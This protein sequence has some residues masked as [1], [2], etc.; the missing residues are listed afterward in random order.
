MKNKLII[1]IF[2]IVNGTLYGQVH[3]GCCWTP[4]SIISGSLRDSVK[5]SI[6]RFEKQIRKFES[7]DSI[8]MPGEGQ[9]LFVGSSSIRGWLS[10]STDM[11]PLPVIRRGFGGSTLPE[12]IHFA[13]RIIYKYKP[14][15]IVLYAGE[16]DMTLDYSIPEDALNSFKEIDSLRKIYLPETH[17]FYL[18]IKPCPTSWYYWPKIKIANKLIQDYISSQPEYLSYIDVSIVLMDKNE[19]LIPEYFMKDGIHLTKNAYSKWA[20]IIKPILISYWAEKNK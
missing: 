15:A 16:N 9:I 6:K 20:E 10:V 11:S 5:K 8:N 17:L 19:Q 3:K 7:E 2:L 18:S 14:K 4:D 1:F 13:P 12:V